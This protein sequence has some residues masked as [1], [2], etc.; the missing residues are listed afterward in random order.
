MIVAMKPSF[1]SD[2]TFM[3]AGAESRGGLYWPGLVTRAGSVAF[4]LLVMIVDG[5]GGASRDRADRGA[6]STS[7]DGPYGCATRGSHGDTSNGS[8]NVMMTTVDGTVVA[9]VRAGIRRV[10]RSGRDKSE[11]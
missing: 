7:G 9:M 6:R 1:Q 3:P 8:A 5:T 2:F 4:R 10:G 11:D